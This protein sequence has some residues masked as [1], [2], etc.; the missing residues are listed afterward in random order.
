MRR[1]GT[2]I[3]TDPSYYSASFRGARIDLVFTGPGE[4]KARLTWVE[5]ANLH[6]LRSQENLPHIAYVT[7]APQRVFIAFPMHFDL[8]LICD[9]VELRSGDI[10]VRSR[11]EHMHLRTVAASDWA[12]LSIVPEYLAKYGKILTGLD[13]VAPSDAGV[14]RPPATAAAHLRRLHAKACRLAETKPDII[15]HREAARA[16]EQDLLHALVNW[17]AVDAAPDPATAKRRHIM[18]RFEKVLVTLSRRPLHL[19]ELCTAVGVSERTLRNCCITTLGMSPHRY[20]RLRRLNMVRTELQHCD[21]SATVQD[22]ARSHGFSEL[23]RFAADYRVAFGEAP[24]VTLLRG[25]R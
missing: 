13:L 19:P 25:R 14:L 18:A 7:P 9:G 22:F 8:P 10:V 17:L 24:S 12:D 15:M 16:L 3:F 11:G 23:G 5:L 1:V 20:V 4:F 21:A 6:L 2:T